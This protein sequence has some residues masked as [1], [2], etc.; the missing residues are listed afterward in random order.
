MN[1]RIL[2]ALL[3]FINISLISH[4]EKFINQK[5]KNKLKIEENEQATKYFDVYDPWEK[6]NRKVYY[7]NYYFDTYFFS[8]VANGYKLITPNIVENGVSNFFKNST[9]ITTM[10]NSTL[11]GKFRKFMRTLGRF[12]INTILGG[13]GIIDVA[14]KLDMPNEY[15][16]FGLTLAYYGVPS[17]PYLILPILGPSNL[18]DATG[19]L[20]DSQGNKIHPYTQSE[21][22]EMSSKKLLIINAIDTRKKVN[23]KYYETGSPFEYDY[24]RFF[25]RE[26]RHFQ[27]AVD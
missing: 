23:F 24:L 21:I 10:V 5:D 6:M 9:N 3:I 16:D 1:K 12:S 20:L 11:Q 25:Y 7:F 17:G 2:L 27:E 14:T 22:L 15:A 13:L 26:F 18:R 8:P 19:K 4:S